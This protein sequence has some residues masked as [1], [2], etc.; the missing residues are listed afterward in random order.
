MASIG[1]CMIVKNE[2]HIIRR[3]L[4]NALPLVDYVLI[5]D[6]GSGDGTQQIIRDFLHEKNLPGEVIDEPWRDFAYNRS[7][8]LQKLRERQDIDYGL[9]IDAD[10]VLVYEAG[11]NAERFKRGLIRDIYDVQ[12]RYG[13]IVYL[14]PQIFSNRIGFVYKGVLHEY[15]DSPG[16]RTRGTAKGFFNRPVQD[17]AR[18][19]NPKKFQDDAT[20]L[21]NV[22]RTETDAF[23]I[24]RY[25]FYLAQ[26][27]RDCG[28]KEHALQAYLR[29][30]GQGYW[31]QEIY[32]SLLNVARIKEQLAYAETEVI[33]A[34]LSA[35]ETLPSR[36]EAL[37]DAIRLCRLRGKYHQ[38]YILANYAL[39]LP[40]PKKGLFLEQW[41]YDYGLLDEFSIVAYWA[42]QYR[43]SFNACLKLLKEVKMP[44]DYRQRILENAHYA[45]EKLKQPSLAKLLP[46]A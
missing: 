12:T 28:D 6:T 33:Q 46:P 10:E 30:S 1:L 34:Y 37:H 15:L 18:S 7:F 42:G 9:M 14:R 22:L 23:L 44:V 3:C 17:S 35:Y 5:V 24:S 27:Y 43:V 4:E 21:E 20:L 41:I 40:C 2:A 39:D 13:G 29:R 16:I 36:L 19:H 8:A 26:S 32:V 45:I 38:A 31:D 11:F 25:T